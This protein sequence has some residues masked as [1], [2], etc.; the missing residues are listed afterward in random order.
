MRFVPIFE[1]FI[2]ERSSNDSGVIE[3]MD[4]HGFQRY[5][6]STLRNKTNVIIYYYF[7]PPVA[8]WGVGGNLPPDPVFSPLHQNCLEIF[9]NAFVTSPRYI[10][11]T[12]P[13]KFS[14]ICYCPSNFGG[15]QRAP[16]MAKN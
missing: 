1:G 10:L 2:G 16:Q 14:Y 4:F 15:K 12:E 8:S 9:L 11:A 5:V 7:N 13:P 3:N 6:F